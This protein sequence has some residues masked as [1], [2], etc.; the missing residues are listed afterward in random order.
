[1][2]LKLESIRDLDDDH[3][4]GGQDLPNEVTVKVVEGTVEEALEALDSSAFSNLGL[5]N[6]A[7][8]GEPGTV[9]FFTFAFEKDIL[10]RFGIE[11]EK[12]PH[13]K[14]FDRYYRSKYVRT[15][16]ELMAA[17]ADLPDDFPL[18][19]TSRRIDSRGEVTSFN[20][21]GVHAT[22]HDWTAEG[23]GESGCH[24]R[25][26]LRLCGFDPSDW[27]K[28]VSGNWKDVGPGTV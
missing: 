17:I 22:C 12:K 10:R 27:D 9:S 16:G 3:V 20:C 11:P 13:E 24:S 19:Q 1:M 23:P 14:A 8:G 28:I 25:W 6:L 26:S 15:V 21:R 5:F 7:P 18:V 4:V 2:E